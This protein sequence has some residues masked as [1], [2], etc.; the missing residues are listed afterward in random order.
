[1]T[2]FSCIVLDATLD[3]KGIISLDTI[4]APRGL[5]E[6][7]SGLQE[8]SN[9]IQDGSKMAP[10][11]PLGGL[12]ATS[13]RWYGIYIWAPFGTILGSKM[14]PQSPHGLPS[15]HH[16]VIHIVPHCNTHCTTLYHIVPH[17]NTTLYHILV[18]ARNYPTPGFLDPCNCARKNRPR[19]ERHPGDQDTSSTD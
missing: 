8:G 6:G 15:G 1:M 3:L 11:G 12:S 19:G 10:R 17:C 13:M 5:Q 2:C 7:P 9:S 14:P 18:R 16:I 4:S